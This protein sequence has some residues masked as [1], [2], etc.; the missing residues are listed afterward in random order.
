MG[1]WAGLGPKGRET[2][3]KGR[4]RAGIGPVLTTTNPGPVKGNP[5]NA[6]D[7]TCRSAHVMPSP[8]SWEV[9][10]SDRPR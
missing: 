6:D 10:T 1:D 8:S 5:R 7:F 4:W 2:G 3:F 9:G